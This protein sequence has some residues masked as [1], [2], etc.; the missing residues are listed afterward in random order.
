MLIVLDLDST[1]VYSTYDLFVNYDCNQH[2]V[3]WNNYFGPMFATNIRILER[4]YL[5]EFLNHL[6]QHFDVAVWSAGKKKYVDLVVDSIFTP[7]H[8]TMLKFVWYREMCETITSKWGTIT[9]KPIQLIQQQIPCYRNEIIYMIDDIEEN[10]FYNRHL[11][12]K[13]NP[14]DTTNAKTD[15]ELL[16]MLKKLSVLR[17]LNETKMFCSVMD[18][19]NPNSVVGVERWFDDKHDEP[20]TSQT[21][22]I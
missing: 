8:K 22:F 20:L 7:K 6:F 4:P 13:I 18:K 10:G 2:V 9:R 15:T 16:K 5:Q 17:D 19:T 12:L 1:L 11:F 3:P 14:F 21:R